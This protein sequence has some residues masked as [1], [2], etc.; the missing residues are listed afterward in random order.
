M[1]YSNAGQP[2]PFPKKYSVTA[3]A[4]FAR[5]GRDRRSRSRDRR[6]RIARCRKIFPNAEGRPGRGSGGREAPGQAVRAQGRLEMGR[7]C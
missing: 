4:F 6:R 5:V 1:Q 7:G 2:R 3:S